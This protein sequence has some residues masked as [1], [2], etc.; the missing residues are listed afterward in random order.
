M[1]AH[2]SLIYISFYGLYAAEYTC[3]CHR[4]LNLAGHTSVDLIFL[5]IQNINHS[6][7]RDLNHH[8]SKDSYLDLLFINPLSH[9]G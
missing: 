6:P 4:L 2:M 1:D 5:F 9:H 8:R 3:S 7:K